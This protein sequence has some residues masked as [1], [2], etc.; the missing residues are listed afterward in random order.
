M[1]KLMLTF[2]ASLV[3]PIDRDLLHSCGRRSHVRVSTEHLQGQ[4]AALHNRHWRLASI[5]RLPSEMQNSRAI[6]PKMFRHLSGE[7]NDGR[8][9]L[10]VSH[11]DIVSVVSWNT[12]SNFCSQWGLNMIRAMGGGDNNGDSNTISAIAVNCSIRNYA[13]GFT[14][15]P[16]QYWKPGPKRFDS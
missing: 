14:G 2:T 12:T 10:C 4:D 16:C 9:A 1:Q 7:A 8:V 5:P 13:A 3:I 15:P 6:P 11:L